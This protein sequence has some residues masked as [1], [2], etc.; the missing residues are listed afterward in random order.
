MSDWILVTL[1]VVVF[2]G[3]TMIVA[4][5]LCSRFVGHFAFRPGEWQRPEDERD[6]FDDD[7]RTAG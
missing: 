7:S 2:L 1:L 4:E 5:W 3:I 6:P